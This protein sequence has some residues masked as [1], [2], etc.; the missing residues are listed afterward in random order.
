MQLTIPSYWWKGRL[1][2][3]SLP[4]GMPR[5]RTGI[6]E[7]SPTANH[8]NRKIRP[9]TTKTQ[10]CYCRAVWVI[11]DIGF[12]PS[13]SI[14]N[15]P[16]NQPIFC[17]FNL[18]SKINYLIKTQHDVYSSSYI[19]WPSLGIWADFRIDIID[20]CLISAKSDHRNV[21]ISWT[22]N[23]YKMFADSR[24]VFAWISYSKS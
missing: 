16:T 18:I 21:Q 1:C 8:A 9:S 13:D 4:Y 7:N 23:N 19:Q 22:W 2:S 14:I 10:F 15:Q 11:L 6:N 17:I 3:V 12:F 24:L 5:V 20:A